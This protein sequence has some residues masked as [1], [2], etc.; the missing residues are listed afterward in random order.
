MISASLLSIGITLDDRW[1]WIYL[2]E[3]QT[4]DNKLY[5]F[6][7]RKYEIKLASVINVKTTGSF[8]HILKSEI[9]SKLCS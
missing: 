5:L 6:L 3:K 9:S 8:T 1:H 7:D 2:Y 4:H